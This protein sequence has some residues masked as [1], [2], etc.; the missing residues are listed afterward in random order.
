ML[1]KLKTDPHTSIAMGAALASLRHNR[2]SPV[3]HSHSFLSTVNER[4]GR[5]IVRSCRAPLFTKE[6]NKKIG[7]KNKNTQVCASR[8]DVR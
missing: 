8:R 3:F 2:K 5:I 4:Q 6:K 1:S 7:E